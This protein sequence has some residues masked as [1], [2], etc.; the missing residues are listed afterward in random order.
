MTQ[1]DDPSAPP[2]VY[3]SRVATDVHFGLELPRNLSLT[4]GGTN[5]F[6]VEPTAQDPNETENGG[7]WENVQ[8]G[9][10]GAAWY[11]RVGW[12]MQ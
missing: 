7:L 12:R 1:L 5:I 9:F 6:D 8:M 10:N 2:Q 3:D 4:V 11:V